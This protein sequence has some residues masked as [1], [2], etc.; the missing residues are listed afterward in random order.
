M[1]EITISQTAPGA[2]LVSSAAGAYAILERDWLSHRYHIIEMTALHPKR[3]QRVCY[4]ATFERA[5][6]EAVA[7]LWRKRRA[8]IAA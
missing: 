2:W 5:L 8:R 1:A 4:R 3:G 6:G 7:R